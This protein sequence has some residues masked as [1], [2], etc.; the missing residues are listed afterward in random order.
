MRKLIPVHYMPSLENGELLIDSDNRFD[1]L[2]TMMFNTG[3][4]SVCGGAF[5]EPGEITLKKKQ[6]LRY[7]MIT[8][9]GKRIF[10]MDMA[11]SDCTKKAVEISAELRKREIPADYFFFNSLRI[12]GTL[13]AAN[14]CT[15]L[16]CY[17]ANI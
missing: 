3:L 13:I 11:A 12:S 5:V 15:L 2:Y 14:S 7:S 1:I 4:V 16:C 6:P 17:Q 10:Y 8:I 9:S